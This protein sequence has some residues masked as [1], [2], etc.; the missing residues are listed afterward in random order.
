V[1]G[2]GRFR[3]SCNL[4]AQ[5]SRFALQI[6]RHPPVVVLR[7]RFFCLGGQLSDAQNLVLENFQPS[8]ECF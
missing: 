2:S 4:Q 1:I 5:L 6:L 7:E 8:L 3:R